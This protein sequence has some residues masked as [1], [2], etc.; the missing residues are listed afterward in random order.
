[1]KA[2]AVL[3]IG[4]WPVHFWLRLPYDREIARYNAIMAGLCEAEAGIMMG[5]SKACLA[6]AMSGAP[7][8]DPS[9]EAETLRN[10]T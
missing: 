9:E 8:D 4:L 5:R 3:A 7:W 2:V 1:M 10:G 6:R